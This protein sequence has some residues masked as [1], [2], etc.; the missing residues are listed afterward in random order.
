MADRSRSPLARHQLAVWDPYLPE[1]GQ[2]EQGAYLPEGVLL[3]PLGPL[4]GFLE[5]LW[6]HLGALLGRLGA[7]LCRL[8]A[9]KTFSTGFQCGPKEHQ[10][11]AQDAPKT[12]P[13]RLQDGPK[14]PRMALRPCRG[15]DGGGGGER[16][17]L[18]EGAL[19]P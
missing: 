1:G 16:R 5:S 2:L 4:G 7:V 10:D 8:G 19:L 9:P 13:R 11:D 6:S 18:A 12:A 14:G 3:G 15:D 17:R